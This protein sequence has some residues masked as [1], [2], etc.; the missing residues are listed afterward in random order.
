MQATAVEFGKIHCLFFQ[1]YFEVARRERKGVQWSGKAH[2]NLLTW[3]NVLKQHPGKVNFLSHFTIHK[4][5]AI[6][7]AAP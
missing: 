6:K 1:T 4:H 2:E 7:S 5:Y 3:L